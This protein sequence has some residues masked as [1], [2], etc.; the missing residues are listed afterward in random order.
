MRT[1]TT[2]RSGWLFVLALVGFGIKAG[3]W[4]LHF[5]L[6]EA[7]PAAPSHVSA[8]LSGVVLKMGI[9]GLVRV[10]S[11][12]PVFPS[13]L[14]LALVGLG[15]TSGILGVVM[16]LAQHDIKR[17][18]AYH[19]IENIGIIVIGLGLAMRFIPWEKLR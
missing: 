9:Y 14:G 16:A 4:P 6:P 13:W 5:W 12:L 10:L 15:V 19:S 18:L 11:M 3:L 2:A 8:L 1:A 7:H 17:L